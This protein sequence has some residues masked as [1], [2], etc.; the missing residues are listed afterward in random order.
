MKTI[1][2]AL[3]THYATGGTRTAWGFRV[4]RNDEQ[5]FGF[6][7][8]SR[9]VDIGGV[10]YLA[11]PGLNI[12]EI[13]QAAAM[14]VDNLKLVTL[15]DGTVFTTDDIH[16]GV[17]NGATFLLF[18]YRWDVPTDGI[19][20]CMEGVFGQPQ[21]RRNYVEIELRDVKQYLQQSVGAPS[22]K[23]CRNRLGV[24]D[25]VTSFCNVY[26]GPLTVV[27][28]VTSTSDAQSFTDSART[29]V[30]DFFGRGRG[31][32]VTGANTG[33][34]FVCKVHE[35]DSN[36]GHFTLD[37]PMFKGITIG[38]QYRLEAGCRLRREEDCFAKFDSVIDFNGEPDRPLLNE[39]IKAPIPSV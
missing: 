36:G 29:E 3:A 33:L 5:V 21:I 26:M 34:R 12:S 35:A 24:N 22:T 37:E 9:D 1:P 15:H 20:E 25:G 4:T 13:V 16:A 6:T 2:I 11:S 14:S 23:T 27:G 18:R 32:W 19:E 39:L 30:D 28:T 38:D 8:A 31:E 17:W 7:S 10:D